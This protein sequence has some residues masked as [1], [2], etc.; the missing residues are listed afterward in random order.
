MLLSEKGLNW[1]KHVERLALM[2]YDDQTGKQISSWV[3]GAT[4]GYGHLI[5]KHE[6]QK[7]RNGITEVEAEDLLRKDLERFVEV[8]KL[9]PASWPSTNSM[10]WLSW[11]TISV[12]TPSKVLPSTRWFPTP[13]SAAR[14]TRTL[15][16]RGRLGTS[17][18]ARPSSA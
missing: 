2:P 16:L 3:K 1:L 4:I 18:R 17:H 12:L 10:P 8:V 5:P 6:W 13:I 11:R 7:Y 14:F 15:K 9:F